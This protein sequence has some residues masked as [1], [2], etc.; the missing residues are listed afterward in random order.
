LCHLL[1]IE[2]GKWTGAIFFIIIIINWNGLRKEHTFL[3]TKGRTIRYLRWGLDNVKKTRAEPS[4]KK[5]KLCT[6]EVPLKTSCSK[7]KKIHA[8]PEMTKNACPTKI[9]QPA[10]PQ[11][12]NGP[13]P[14]TWGKL[15]WG[16]GLST[17]TQVVSESCERVLREKCSCAFSIPL[18]TNSVLLSW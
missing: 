11:I 18:Q 7:Q 14:F 2:L 9:V 16:I 12:S 5:K 1:W 15:S 3:L 13:A 10:P 6:T 8:P 17:Q 4:S